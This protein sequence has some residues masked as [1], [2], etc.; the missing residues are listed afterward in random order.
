[1]SRNK[2]IGSL[3]AISAL[4]L[5]STAYIGSNTEAYLKNYVERT[6]KIYEQYGFKVSLEAFEKGFFSSKANMNMDF[7]EPDMREIFSDTFKLP[8]KMNYNIENGPIFFEKGLGFGSSRIEQNLQASDYVVEEEAFKKMFKNDIMFNSSMV[9]GFAGNA[10]FTA[11]SNPIVA[12]IEG[13]TLTMSPL[14]ME[15]DM[16]MDTFEG[17]VKMFVD[18]LVASQGE[19]SLT[20]KSLLL[21]ADITKF[22]A[23][24]FYLGDFL[25]EVDSLSTKGAILPISL[26]NAKVSL[27][28]LIDENKDKSIDM[29]FNI[30]A[31]T[32]NSVL[33]KEYASLK[34]VALAYALNGTSLKGLL[35]F[36]DF[37]K[38]LEA[39]QQAL[40]LKLSSDNGAF[41]MEALEELEKFQVEAEEEMML[42]LAGLLNKDR[43]NLTVNM[44]LLDKQDKESSLNMKVAYVGDEVL[45]TTSKDLM[46]KFTKDFLELL[47]VDLNIELNKDYIA[48][49]PVELQEKLAPQLQMGTMLGVVKDNNVS[50]RFDA[51]YQP[52]TLMVN[53]EDRT[54]MLQMLERGI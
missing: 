19:D 13:D 32:R 3:V 52:K 5:G 41:D 30:D 25:F 22:Y 18:S 24:G 54:E 23:N 38:R 47:A 48:N 9:I 11:H 53:G 39:K 12:D 34:K 6:N 37:T 40:A 42:L 27:G 8:M 1:M 43:T 31:D 16:D 15:G 14:K 10:S 17:K 28:M 2:I 36:Q 4:W 44:N 46:E 20:I 26:E 45:P 33:P 49:L 7:I 35:A 50:Y 29:K 51:K 21:D